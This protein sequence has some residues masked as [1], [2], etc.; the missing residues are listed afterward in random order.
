MEATSPDIQKLLDGPAMAPPPG[1]RPNFVN[2][3]N[4]K[5]ELYADV[6]ICLVVSTV[7][8]SMRMWTKIRLIRKLGLEDCTI[9]LFCHTSSRHDS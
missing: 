8:V 4:F 5:A 1:Q 9:S 6:I 2:P 7:V 3:S